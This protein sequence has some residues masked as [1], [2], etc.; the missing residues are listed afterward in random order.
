MTRP[1]LALLA[2]VSV[3]GV[4][5]T[6]PRP[7]GGEAA[8]GAATA[9]A[10]TNV[11]GAHRDDEGA[12]HDASS[13]ALPGPKATFL[14]VPRSS[15]PITP[16]GKFRIAVWSGA[17]ST[18]TL[19]DR[20]GRGAVPVGEARLLWSEGMLYVFFYAGDLDLQAHT[21]KH[22]GPVWNDDSVAFAFEAADGKK[23]VIQVS[24]TGVIAD[25]VCPGDATGLADPR[26]DLRWESG[27][28]AAI[29]FDGKLNSIDDRDEEWAVE[30]AIP[31][32]P[33]GLVATEGARIPF[34]V[35]RCEVAHDGPRACGA[36]GG[37]LGLDPPGPKVS[38]GIETR[39][40][41]APSGLAHK[42]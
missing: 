26:C 13:A 39:A 12:A 2:C 19:L 27:A 15:G 24:V 23:H 31:L 33:L 21:T 30:A 40:T 37:T 32:A 7:E 28:R 4:A 8:E 36:W 17:P 35:S 11:D 10:I 5:C 6:T 18:G 1:T 29:D 38:N 34:A 14:G 20:E 25:G 22:D 3:G 42:M 41:S 16:A 9:A